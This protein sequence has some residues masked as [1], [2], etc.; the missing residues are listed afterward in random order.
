[1]AERMLFDLAGADDDRR[2]SPY[3]WRTRMA[4]AH[5]RLPVD[6]VP[7]RFTE[8][9]RIAPAAKVPVLVDGP[10][11]IADS[12][13][14]ALYLEAT[15]RDAP[16]LFGAPEA[17][18]VT[19]FLNAWTDRVL[20]PGIAPLIVRD[21]HDCL[22]EKDQTYFRASRERA[23]GAT[24]EQVMA[25]RDTRVTAFRRSLDPLRVLLRSQP[26]IGG[27][28]PTYADYI[29]FGTLQWPRCSSNFPLLETTDAIAVW[30]ETML[31]LFDG[32]GRRALV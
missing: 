23:F 15:Y 24:L 29:V 7:W 18:P 19:R 16:S 25:D 17:V 6:A 1:M 3:C 26:Y 13:E 21:I 32:L 5:K 30:F 10:T 12:W 20:V 9:A 2:F 27:T 22:H 14:I 8:T 31:D 4:L 11:T 28:A